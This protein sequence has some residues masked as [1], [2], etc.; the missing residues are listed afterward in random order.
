MQRGGL[1]SSRKVMET[2][3]KQPMN[4]TATT[5]SAKSYAN[6]RPARVSY[7]SIQKKKPKRKPRTK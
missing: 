7:G 6:L 1:Y 5:T 4:K 2:I 3:S